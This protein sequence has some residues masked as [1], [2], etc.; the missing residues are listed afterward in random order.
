MPVTWQI[1]WMVRVGRPQASHSDWHRSRLT[2]GTVGGMSSPENMSLLNAEVKRFHPLCNRI[3][4]NVTPIAHNKNRAK[5]AKRSR[6]GSF[7]NTFLVKRLQDFEATV[8]CWSRT[9]QPILVNGLTT[10]EP[11]PNP[12]STDGHGWTA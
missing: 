8:R 6:V 11:N 9:D 7:C 12:E 10:M 2:S 4:E 5:R 3:P 1:Y